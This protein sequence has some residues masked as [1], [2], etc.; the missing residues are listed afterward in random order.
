MSNSQRDQ[1]SWQM[2]PKVD[3]QVPQLT[4]ASPAGQAGES[5]L[6]CFP[7]NSCQG[8]CRTSGSERELRSGGGLAPEFSC[9]PHH[10]GQQ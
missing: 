10:Y 5:D 2:H 3:S 1:V 6:H 8:G 9:S 4:F 7:N